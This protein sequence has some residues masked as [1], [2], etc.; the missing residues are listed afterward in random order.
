M[1]TT[2]LLSISTTLITINPESVIEKGKGKCYSYRTA[3][4]NK[5]LYEI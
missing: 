2:Y 5:Q 1:F 3:C 4:K